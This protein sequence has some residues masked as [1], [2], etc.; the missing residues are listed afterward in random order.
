MYYIIRVKV[1]G[2]EKFLY[3]SRLLVTN[4]GYARKFYSLYYAKRYLKNHPN[5]M[6][7]GCEIVAC[8]VNENG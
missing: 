5:I 6:W 4:M 7:D 3:D 2:K 8:T 1:E